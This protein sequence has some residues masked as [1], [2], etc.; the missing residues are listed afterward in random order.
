MQVHPAAFLMSS[1]RL[2]SRWLDATILLVSLTAIVLVPHA[3]QSATNTATSAPPLSGGNFGSCTLLPQGW[4][5]GN[6]EGLSGTST[7]MVDGVAETVLRAQGVGNETNYQF[8]TTQKGEFPWSPCQAPA[9][10]VLPA[11]LTS[12]STTFT[13]KSFTPSGTYRYHIYLALYYWLPSGPVTASGLTYRCLDTQ[14]RAENINGNFS[15]VGTVATYD[16]GD[17]FG[18]DQVTIDSVSTGGTYTLTANVEQ[19]C[20]N[21]LGAWGLPTN[22]PCQLA[23]VEIGIEGFQFTEL[24]VYWPTYTFIIPSTLTFQGFDWDGA[25]EETLTMN[26]QPLVSLPAVDSPQN[27]QVYTTFTVNVTSFVASGTNALVFTHGNWDCAVND[28]VKNLQ[29]TD[30]SNTVLFSDPTV[31]TL[32]CATSI[33][34]TLSPIQA[35]FAVPGFLVT[36]RLANYTASALSG[37]VPYSF[38]WSFDDGSSAAGTLVSHTFATSGYHNVTLNVSDRNGAVATVQERVLFWK[39]PSVTGDSCVT[40]LDVAQVAFAFGSAIGERR[41]DPRLDMNI[42]GRIDIQDVAF[43]AFYF[44]SCG[45]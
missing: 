13:L 9:I 19:Q 7:T 33:I 8:A 1:W 43:L 27:G 32:N 24:S 26:N 18:W 11:G 37:T 36:G 44:G 28:N 30:N 31:R 22:T 23:G 20:Q 14:V 40:I 5:C 17:S 6:G 16:P 29:V 42:D 34:Y 21:D 38:S 25:G 10:G 15:P 4:R 35:A 3:A 39:K 2:R 12:V 45:W 41:Y